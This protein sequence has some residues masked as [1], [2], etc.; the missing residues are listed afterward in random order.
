MIGAEEAARIGFCDEIA[1]DGAVQARAVEAAAALA[2][3]PPDAFA[4]LKQIMG[5]LSG[6]LEAAL[7]A[8]VDAQDACFRGPEFAEGLRA[9]REKRTPDFRRG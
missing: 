4:R 6:S 3:Q 9:F 8:E 1:E 2:Q 5:A 7:E